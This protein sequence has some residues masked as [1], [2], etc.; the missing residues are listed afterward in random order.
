MG[1]CDARRRPDGP[2]VDGGR[3]RPAAADGAP[4]AW[5]QQIRQPSCALRPGW[6]EL[7]EASSEAS[8]AVES[9]LGRLGT[10]KGTRKKWQDPYAGKF[11]L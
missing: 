4:T 10:R 1:R 6:V 2:R 3:V 9:A 11:G 5:G 7:T 8:A